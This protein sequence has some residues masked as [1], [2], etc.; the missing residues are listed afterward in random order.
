MN[1]INGFLYGQLFQKEPNPVKNSQNVVA[2]Q[3][4]DALI[5]A[6]VG[7]QIFH[8]QPSAN[9][10]VFVNASSAKLGISYYIILLPWIPTNLLKF[11]II[12]KKELKYIISVANVNFYV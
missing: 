6:N 9:V 7:R 2:T 10:W 8:V 5:D 1:A 4:W 3:I 11:P 12:E